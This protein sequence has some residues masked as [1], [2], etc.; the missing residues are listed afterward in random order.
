[1]VESGGSRELAVGLRTAA[2]AVAVAEPRPVV[3]AGLSRMVARCPGLR[4]HAAVGSLES[5]PLDPEP[6]DVLLVGPVGSGPAFLAQLSRLQSQVPDARV[7]LV[8]NDGADSVPAQVV[9]RAHGLLVDPTPARVGRV[10]R[11]V[12]EGLCYFDGPVPRAVW[13]WVHQPSARVQLSGPEGLALRLV[14]E[15]CSNAQIARQLGCTEPAAK[16]LLRSLMRKL[17]ARNRAHAAALA[18][19]WRL[20]E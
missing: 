5:V 20:V 10:V 7:V 4:L 1:M 14:A 18:V 19:R 6:P 11:A 9:A 17:G 8:W 3:R 13:G 12:Y 15:G 2:V 16:A